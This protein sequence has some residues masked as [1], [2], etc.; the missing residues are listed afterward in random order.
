MNY[1]VFH[2]DYFFDLQ[3][4]LENRFSCQEFNDYIISDEIIEKLK[5]NIILSP[6]SFNSLPFRIFCIKNKKI[7]KL[8]HKFSYFQ[9]QISTCSH[10]FVFCSI[11]NIDDHLSLMEETNIETSGFK[12]MID[13]MNEEEVNNWSKRQCYIAMTNLLISCAEENIDS[14]PMEGFKP[15]MYKNILKLDKNLE[16]TVVVAIGKK[17]T[18]NNIKKIRINKNKIITDIN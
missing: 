4:I 18:K 10:L 11:K 3:E 17:A 6:S 5:C 7:L 12:R 14:C 15:S 1:R 2:G 13:N 9:N 8:L 16:P